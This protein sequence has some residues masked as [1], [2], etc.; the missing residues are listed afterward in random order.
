MALLFCLLLGGSAVQAQ[1]R[2]MVLSVE[3]IMRDP[4]WIGTSPDNVFW[5]EDG[6]KVYFSWNPEG[7]RYDS[8]YSV[9]VSGKNMKKV[10]AQERRNLPSPYGRYN[11]ARTKKVYEKNGDIFLYDIKS[12]KVQQVT[13]TTERESSPSFSFDEQ[14]VLY[15]SNGNMFSWSHS[16]G[17][18]RQLSDFRKG[19]K[20]VAGEPKDAQRD[21]L[22]EQQLALLQI[23]RDRET[24]DK[25]QQQQRKADSPKRPK[26]IYIDDKSADNISLSPDE[27]FITYWLVSRPKNAKA[28]IVPNFITA[29]GYTED[30]NARTK[31]GDAQATI[32]FYIYDIQHDTTFA[33]SMK[34]VEGVYEQPAYLKQ[35]E[36]SAGNSTGGSKAKQP[37][38]RA[39]TMYGPFWSDNGKHAVVVARSADNK[40]RWILKLDPATGKLS[41]LDRQR[42]E[43]WIN[44]PGISYGAGDIG[45]M[46][47]NEHVWFQSEESGY[48]H[49]Y[50]V[51]V[52]N[53]RKKAL[54]A[55]KFEVSGLKMSNDKKSWYF[56]ANKVHPGEQHF[57][58]MPIQGGEMVQLTTMSGAHEVQLSPNEKTLAI[59]YSYSNKP[60]ELFLMDNKKGATPRQ[61]TE[62]LTDEFKSYNW[63]E[64]EV[65][66]FKARD[67]VDVYA[68]L[69]KP[70]AA[71]ANGPAVIFVHGAGYLQNAHK[72]WSSYFRE[73]MFHNFLVDQGY[74]VLDMDYRGSAG[75]G[76]DVRTGIYQFMGG[77]DLTDHVDGAKFLAE[78]HQVDPKRIGIYGGSYG[79]FIT[80]MAMFTQ[81][82][83][84]A[85]GAALRSV[86]DW[87][88]YNHGYTSNILNTPYTDS[89][90]YAKSSPIYYAEGLKGALLMCHGM[91]DTNV[92]FQ[93]IVRLSQRL[94]ELGKDN[95]E[96]AVYPVENHGFTEPASWTDEYKRIFKLF[97][98]NLK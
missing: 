52:N 56:T 48:S 78:Q 65:I 73:Y 92:H 15:L 90:A 82:D 86:T 30:I 33:P 9:L 68:R 34:D 88:H 21:W 74:T 37:E 32:E 53:G 81:P 72:W 31:V 47:D 39:T 75:Y 70:A 42:D 97:E 17:Q 64:P 43:A 8:L 50:T 67:G 54:T 51:N 66:S 26:E 91:V 98:E 63:R 40:D 28:T 49:L 96:L 6:S 58:R 13:N 87:A 95:W 27:R 45:F 46:P 25:A 14:E 23:V 85:A 5:S 89:L 84:F 18:V 94:I 60:W 36:V 71:K 35:A 79:G 2:N 16:S 44:G 1:Q 76:R 55:G 19:R 38:P 61:I 11:K 29:S 69:Y 3:K 62:S 10:S 59:R 4:K 57:Y 24:D 83:V 12:G 22:K 80:L 41:L 7:N 20:P 77:K 93:D